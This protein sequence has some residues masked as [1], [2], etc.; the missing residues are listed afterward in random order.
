[1]VAA[2]A[3]V[4]EARLNFE[5]EPTVERH[6]EQNKGKQ[7]LFNTSDA[8]KGEKQMEKVQRVQAAQDEQLHGEA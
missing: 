6:T 4:R 7:L 3:R 2:R 8:I 1:M 5:K